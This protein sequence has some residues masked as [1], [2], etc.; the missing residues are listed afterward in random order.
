MI[1]A[2]EFDRWEE[3]SLMDQLSWFDPGDYFEVAGSVYRV[4]SGDSFVQ[5][6]PS[7]LDEIDGVSYSVD[8]LMGRIPEAEP[9]SPYGLNEDGLLTSY[10][11]I[12][13]KEDMGDGELEVELDTDSEEID[14]FEGEVRADMAYVLRHG[15]PQPSQN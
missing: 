10:G 9:L 4:D 11:W 13:E 14:E 3:P 6:D 8:E 12:D 15:I 7:T 2:E 5:V 1:D